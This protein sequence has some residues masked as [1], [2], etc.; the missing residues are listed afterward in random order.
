MIYELF[1]KTSSLLFSVAQFLLSN[2][3]NSL[4]TRVWF[5]IILLIVILV[6]AKESLISA[7]NPLHP[8]SSALFR[9]FSKTATTFAFLA[10]YLI[11]IGVVLS[12]FSLTTGYY[13]KVKQ[14]KIEASPVVIFEYAFDAYWVIAKQAHLAQL[15]GAFAGFL[16]SK[17]ITYWLLPTLNSAGLGDKTTKIINRLNRARPFDPLEY[18]NLGKG[19]FLGLNLKGQPLYLSQRKLTETH[20]QVA[21]GTGAGKG[22]L[23]SI[24]ASQFLM[25]DRCVICFD[26]KFDFNMLSV[27]NDISKKFGKT[28]AYLD[29]T[30]YRSQINPFLGASGEQIADLLFAA[31]DLGTTGTDGDYHRGREADCVYFLAKQNVHSLPDLIAKAHDD[32]IV[33][34]EENFLR[35][36]RLLERVG[37]FMTDDGPDLKKLIAEG[38]CIYIRASSESDHLIRAQKLLLLRVL[39]IIKDE[40]RE[41]REVSLVLDEFKYLLSE[42]ALMALGVVRSFGC[43][44]VLAH[45]SS[46]DLRST[47][48]LDGDAVTSIVQTNTTLKFI[49]RIPDVEFAQNLS[50]S[51]LQKKGFVSSSPKQAMLS[52]VDAEGRWTEITRPSISSHLLTNLPMPSDRSTQMPVTSCVMFNGQRVEV[53]TNCPMKSSGQVPSIE[54][55]ASSGSNKD[56]SGRELI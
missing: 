3:T 52:Q 39:Q 54:P 37:A 22:V 4:P 35:K 18:I 27:L 43:Q 26:P 28:M 13:L 25:L 30:D 2:I 34:Q 36:L 44:A 19:I 10:A 42:G 11:C 41:P 8:K 6:D 14:L 15:Y 1:G 12:A 9:E 51:T 46:G 24:L 21:G 47:P 45:Q 38:A 53:F 40:S 55:V 49:F 48:K 20:V 31:L 23:L 32:P 50:Q 33:N 16:L 56:L 17:L 5:L 29:L 7:E